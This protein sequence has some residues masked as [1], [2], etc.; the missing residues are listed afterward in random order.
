YDA[1][2][3]ITLTDRLSRFSKIG[4]EMVPHQKIEDEVQAI[5]K[6]DERKIVVVGIPDPGKG[7]RLIV[8]HTPLSMD[9]KELWKRLNDRGLPNLWVPKSSDFFEVPQLPL[10][11]IGKLDLNQ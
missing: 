1:D 9:V 2:G 6:S 5:L 11:G 8:L 3:F 7:E 10:V 4:G